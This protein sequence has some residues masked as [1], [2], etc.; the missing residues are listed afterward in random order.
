MVPSFIDM[1]VLEYAAYPKKTYTFH[2]PKNEGF[3]F[4]ENESWVY[5]SGNKA[6]LGI[7]DWAQRIIG[8]MLYY[9]LPRAGDEL[10]ANEPYGQIESIKAVL[11]L[12]SPVSGRVL[13]V[14]EDILDIPGIIT[15]SCYE[16]GWICC[17][18]LSDMENDSLD[19]M[20]FDEYWPL[21]K[22]KADNYQ[23]R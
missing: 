2:V 12:I 9:Q 11:E 10:A 19:M 5:V 23:G 4:G 22:S 1:P 15:E 18:E 20:E 16:K 17:L 6:L 7:T 13:E 8:Q 3:W 14:N 21:M